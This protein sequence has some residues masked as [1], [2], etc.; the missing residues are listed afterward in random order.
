MPCRCAFSCVCCVLRGNMAVLCAMCR[1]LIA[2]VCVQC[3]HKPTCHACSHIFRD[4]VCMICLD[5][6]QETCSSCCAIEVSRLDNVSALSFAGLSQCPGIH[7]MDVSTSFWLCS[8]L[9]VVSMSVTIGCLW[10]CIC[11]MDW[12][13]DCESVQMTMS[14]EHGGLVL[15]QSLEMVCKAERI[16]VSSTSS[17]LQ[18]YPHA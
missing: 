12:I 6:A 18:L 11:A 17:L 2:S 3:C 8:L 15:S 7:W 4:F 5:V 14:F 9:A 1:W 16:A 13:A 10:C